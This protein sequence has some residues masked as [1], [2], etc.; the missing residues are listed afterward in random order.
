MITDNKIANNRIDYF[1]I[2]YYNNYNNSIEGLSIMEAKKYGIKINFNKQ[3]WSWKN[4]KNMSF[5]V[6]NDIVLEHH[7]GPIGIYNIETEEGFNKMIHD[8]TD[9]ARWRK[10]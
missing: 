3:T 4:I 6:R 2:L 9:T 8:I 10:Y 7:T 5:E 1:K